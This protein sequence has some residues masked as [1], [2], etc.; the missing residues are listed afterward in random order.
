MFLVTYRPPMVESKMFSYRQLAK[1]LKFYSLLNIL[2]VSLSYVAIQLYLQDS[3]VPPK[4]AQH[5]TSHTLENF[6]AKSH[7]LKVDTNKIAFTQ[8]RLEN[9]EISSLASSYNYFE[10][11]PLACKYS[12]SLHQKK[13]SSF[14]YIIQTRGRAPPQLI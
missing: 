6:H 1:F 14:H 9:I 10:I 8:S 3:S 4:L 11:L 2:A 7:S 13:K 12:E 5:K